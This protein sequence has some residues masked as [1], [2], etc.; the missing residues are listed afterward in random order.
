MIPSLIRKI[1]RCSLIIYCSNSGR[2]FLFTRQKHLPL[3]ACLCFDISAA[4]PPI[5]VGGRISLGCFRSSVFQALS[6]FA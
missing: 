1:L 2:P 6:L 4:I 3:Y 5:S